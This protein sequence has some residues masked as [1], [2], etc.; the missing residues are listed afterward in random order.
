MFGTKPDKAKIEERVLKIVAAYD[1]ITADKVKVTNH[2]LSFFFFDLHPR[3]VG[4][5]KW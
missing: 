4:L 2:T 5:T 1:K 3:L